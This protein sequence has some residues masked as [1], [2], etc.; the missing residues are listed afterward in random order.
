LK[1]VAALFIISGIAAALEVLISLTRSRI[2]LNFGILGIFI[3]LGLHRFRHGWRTCALVLTWLGLLLLPV[4]AVL[5]LAGARPLYVKLLGQRVGYT[6][7]GVALL[8]SAAVFALSL[9]QYRVLTRR[10]VVQLFNEQGAAPN[11]G[12]ATPPG[13]LG[14]TEGPPSVS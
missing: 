12:P 3:G 1:I 9:W 5:V 13:D 6:S 2:S 8:L 4:F 7:P 10:D 14:L 11:G